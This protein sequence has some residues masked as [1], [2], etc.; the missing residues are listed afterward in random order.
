ML[1]ALSGKANVR[2]RITRLIYLVAITIATLG[3]SWMLM[4]GLGWTFGG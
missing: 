3:W 1:R 2:S 4:Q